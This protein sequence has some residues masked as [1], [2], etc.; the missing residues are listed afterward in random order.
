[1]K[2]ANS[3]T[4]DERMQVEREAWANFLLLGGEST[5]ATTMY[6]VEP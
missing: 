5:V 1:M 6:A 2:G 4:I 3:M